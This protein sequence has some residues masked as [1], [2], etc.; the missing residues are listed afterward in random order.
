MRECHLDDGASA[1]AGMAQQLAGSAPAPAASAAAAPRS[2]IQ[3]IRD[4]MEATGPMDAGQIAAVV[5]TDRAMVW[6]LI[7]GDLASGRM[8]RIAGSKPVLVEL[9]THFGSREVISWVR[10]A[11][12]TMPDSE[13]TL[14]LCD[15]GSD[16]PVPWGGFWSGTEWCGLDG[17]PCEVE[18]T[19]YAH[20]PA[21]PVAAS[22]QGGGERSSAASSS[23]RRRST[24][25]QTA[26]PESNAA[27]TTKPTPARIS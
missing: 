16:D 24:A 3:R 21:G 11:P 4:A 20:W 26:A 6:P 14:L 22:V 17:F 12:G 8:R 2:L 1:L 18:P 9:G 10:V 5:R 25:E 15:V 23:R 27:Q 13:L 19:H 7:K